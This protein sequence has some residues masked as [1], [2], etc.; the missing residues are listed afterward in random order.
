M[1]GVQITNLLLNAENNLDLIIAKKVLEN[2]LNLTKL[3]ESLNDKGFLLSREDKNFVY[4]NLS[5]LDLITEYA[6]S[7]K[8]I[9]FAT[10]TTAK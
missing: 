6:T 5:N 3:L 4:K 2:S 10:K 9:C 8:K 1:P 7:K